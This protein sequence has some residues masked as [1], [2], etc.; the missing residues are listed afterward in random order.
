M[1]LLDSA[2][3]QAEQTRILAALPGGVRATST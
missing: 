2:W 3:A 1:S